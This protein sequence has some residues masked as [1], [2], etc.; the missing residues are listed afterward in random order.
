MPHYRLYALDLD[1]NVLFGSGFIGRNDQ[2]ALA[3]LHAVWAAGDRAE[4]WRGATQL[5]FTAVYDQ[6]KDV[7]Q[8]G[9]VL[10]PPDTVTVK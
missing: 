6:F 9:M 2:E 5:R 1:N 4:I 3:V 10:G 7:S 8:H